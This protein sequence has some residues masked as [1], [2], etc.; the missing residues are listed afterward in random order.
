MKARVQWR[1]PHL[2]VLAR[3]AHDHQRRWYEG[4]GKSREDCVQSPPCKTTGGAAHKRG[5][6]TRAGNSEHPKI[7]RMH[8]LG[9]PPEAARNDRAGTMCKVECHQAHSAGEGVDEDAPLC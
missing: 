6:I 8:N 3:V 7:K 5:R 4:L 2:K 1:Q 9:R